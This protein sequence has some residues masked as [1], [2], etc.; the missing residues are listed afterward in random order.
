MSA[1]RQ[2][3]RRGGFDLHDDVVPV[4]KSVIGVL[5]EK[6]PIQ[7]RIQTNTNLSIVFIL[8]IVIALNSSVVPCP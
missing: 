4:Y 3:G 8:T 6:E 2:D 7:K 1:T 5:D